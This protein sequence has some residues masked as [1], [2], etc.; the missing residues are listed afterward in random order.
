MFSRKGGPPDVFL[1]AFDVLELDGRDLRA[2]S[3]TRAADPTSG[4]LP[5]R[6]PLGATSFSHFDMFCSRVP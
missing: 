6:P 1:Y 3:T 4:S 2:Q 5:R